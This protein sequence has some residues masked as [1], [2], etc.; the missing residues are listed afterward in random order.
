MEL[1][2]AANPDSG[3]RLAY[4]IRVPVGAGLVFAT[5]GTWPRA[6]AL[7]CH[8]L[9]ADAWP[10]EPELV[11]HV[12]LRACRR[13]G[14]AV[15]IV[16]NRFR[17]NR[18]QLVYTTARGRDVVF[19][20]SP[21]TSKQSRPGVRTPT[22]RA[23]GIAELPVVVDARERY[24]Y[25]FAG[26][27]VVTTRQALPCGDYGLMADGRLIAVVERKSLSDLVS[28]LLSGKLKYQLTDL[29]A[30]PRA[31]V[32]VEDR[33]S[34]I[35]TLAVARPAVVADGLAEVQIAFPTVPIVF[36]QTRKL[37]QEYTYR[38]LAAAHD[39]LTDNDDAATVFESPSVAPPP[40]EPPS[41][42][43][44][45]GAAE[46]SVSEIRAWARGVGLPVPA[47][48][49]ISRDILQAWHDAHHR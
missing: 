33:F 34:E 23:A 29:A 2:V 4:L 14:A 43:P 24:G 30:V 15:D 45:S 31:A 1:L 41:V 7:Y 42:E 47:R 16:A 32:V 40:V 17:E 35:F 10:A 11:E 48:G 38:Y 46:A 26:K 13:R 12:E 21:R 27:P 39:W 3:S 49:R 19:W 22:A 36:C 20:Q 37:A 6:K 44:P 25:S 8:P 28:S 18:S 9:P 5:S